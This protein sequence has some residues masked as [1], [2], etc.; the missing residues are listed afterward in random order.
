MG[1]ISIGGHLEVSRKDTGETVLGTCIRELRRDGCGWH[2]VRI[3]WTGA[4]AFGML[5]FNFRGRSDAG[6][7]GHPWEC[8]GIGHDRDC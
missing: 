7:A 2:V 6:Y 4:L 1:S 3:E 8:H 5:G